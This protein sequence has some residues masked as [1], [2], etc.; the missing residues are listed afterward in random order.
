MELYA[1]DTNSLTW[2]FQVTCSDFGDF[3]FF[4]DF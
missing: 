1:L 4:F 3:I 2:V